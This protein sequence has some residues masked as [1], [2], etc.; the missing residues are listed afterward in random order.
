MTWVQTTPEAS[1]LPHILASHS[2]N[3]A[4]LEAHQALYRTIMFGSSPLSRAEREA[5]AVAVSAA[6]DCHY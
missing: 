1:A 5:I 3:P 4:A 2:L 6:N